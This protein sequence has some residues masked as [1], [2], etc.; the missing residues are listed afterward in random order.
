MTEIEALLSVDAGKT[1]PETVA[2]FLDD[3]T[4][5]FRRT[6]AVV[7]VAAGL[8]AGASGFAGLGHGC[9]ALLLLTA[10]LLALRAMPTLPEDENRD[11]KRQVLVITRFGIIVRDL[12]GLRRWRFDELRDVVA[13][14]HGER[15][16]L[17]FIDRDGK[18]HT[19]D[20]A[21]YRHGERAR[22]VV[23]ARLR[24][25]TTSPG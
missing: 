16:F 10:G 13:G 12:S 9:V 1:P 19:V 18:R 5:A 2:V 25:K 6:P 8:A 22:R 21:A 14:I 23:S 7:A 17:T 24:V 20:C 3:G 15:P 11:P 4:R